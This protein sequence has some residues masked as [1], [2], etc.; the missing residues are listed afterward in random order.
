M[1]VRVCNA[2]A[3]R[4]VIASGRATLQ[5]SKQRLYEDAELLR[6]ARNDG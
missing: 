3:E 2:N 1:P 4:V 5:S 6:D